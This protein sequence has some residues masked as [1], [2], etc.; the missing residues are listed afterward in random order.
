MNRHCKQIQESKTDK[1]GINREIERGIKRQTDT[2]QNN[3]LPDD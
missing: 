1:L 2:K 3:A